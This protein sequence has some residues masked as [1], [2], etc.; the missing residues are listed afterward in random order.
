MGEKEFI[1]WAKKT[2]ETIDFGCSEIKNKALLNLLENKNLVN[3]E[4]L[5]MLLNN[6]MIT[7]KEY[8]LELLKI[9]DTIDDEVTKL[10]LMKR[11]NLE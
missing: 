7:K 6:G 10:T 9:V 11:L 2:A 8:E 3:D 4:L 1:K 5:K